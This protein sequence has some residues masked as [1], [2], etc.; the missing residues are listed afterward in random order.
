[1]MMIANDGREKKPEDILRDQKKK[2]KKLNDNSKRKTVKLACSDR[3]AHALILLLLHFLVHR[4]SE[5]SSA[6]RS[7]EII[8]YILFVK[9]VDLYVWGVVFF[10][11]HSFVGH[12]RSCQQLQ[13]NS[14]W[15]SLWEGEE[16]KILNSFFFSG[17]NTIRLFF[18]RTFFFRFYLVFF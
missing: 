1:M 2:N 6:Q 17:T 15:E 10:S 5:K 14:E 11:S 3:S 8:S 12:R 9:R 13:L 18:F 7:T 16:K 4:W